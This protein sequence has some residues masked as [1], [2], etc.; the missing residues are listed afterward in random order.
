MAWVTKRPFQGAAAEMLPKTHDPTSP[1]EHRWLIAGKISVIEQIAYKNKAFIIV[2]Q[3]THCTTGDKLVIPNFSLAGSVQSKKHGFATFVHER[4]EW[5]LVDQSPEQSEAEWVCVDVAGYKII[6][7]YKPPRSRFTPKAIPTFPHPNLYVG[8]FNCQHVNWSYNKTSPDGES[9][10]SWAT[11]NNLRLV[12]NPKETPSFFSHRWDVGTNP[13]L[14]FASFGQDSRLLDRYVLGQFPRPQHRPSL[15]T[16]PKLN[17]PAHS[18]PVKRWN[19]HKTDW[20]RFYLLTG[21]YLERLPPPDTSN[22]ERAYQDF[23]ESLLSAA[24]QRNPRGRRKNYVP[25]WDKE[26][27]TLYRSFTR[28]PVGTDCDRA[29]SSLLSRLGQKKQERL[30]EATIPSTSRTLAARRRE[31]SK[32]LLAGLD[33]PFACAPSRQIPSPRN[34]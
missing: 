31:P 4:L 26:R 3:E 33:A 21:E 22:I 9:R 20:R 29:A 24:K 11:F 28:A 5:S 17:V 30:E 34:S 19:F 2:L 32:N 14:A 6:N 13:D 27:E 8:D 7:V 23:C 10:E 18:D 12:H 15:I 16:P 1:A 25:C